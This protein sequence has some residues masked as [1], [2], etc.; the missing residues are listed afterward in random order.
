MSDLKTSIQNVRLASA[1]EG[2]HMRA[3]LLFSL[4]AETE[5]MSE[6]DIVKMVRQA[7]AQLGIKDPDPAPVQEAVTPVPAKQSCSSTSVATAPRLKA[8]SVRPRTRSRVV[9]H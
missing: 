4:V 8:P 1:M 9:V 3:S 5:D 6:D 7:R 2:D